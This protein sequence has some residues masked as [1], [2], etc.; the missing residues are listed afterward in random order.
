MEVI[1]GLYKIIRIFLTEFCAGNCFTVRCVPHNWIGQYYCYYL[2]IRWKNG[3]VLKWTDNRWISSVIPLDD[4]N[5]YYYSNQI[6]RIVKLLSVSYNVFQLRVR[7]ERNEFL[8]RIIFLFRIWDWYFFDSCY[9]VVYRNYRTAT[10]LVQIYT[11]LFFYV[12]FD[13]LFSGSRQI[14]QSI[15]ASAFY[16]K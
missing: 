13:C 8:W 10:G 5:C 9:P 3:S 1:E 7:L 16:R 4:K 11:R 12:H 2:R 6:D 15:K 14:L